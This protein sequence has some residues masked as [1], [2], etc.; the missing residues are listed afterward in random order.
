MW[1][2]TAFSKNTRIFEFDTMEEA[3]ETYEK[4]KGYKILTE[5]I[6]LY[7]Y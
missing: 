5:V 1:I 7:N 2:I 6:C 3:K 4:I